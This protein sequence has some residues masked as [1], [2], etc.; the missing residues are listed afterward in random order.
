[1][2]NQNIKL[3]EIKKTISEEDFL[4]TIVVGLGMNE[5]TPGDVFDGEF[6]N[7]TC[8]N[9]HFVSIGGGAKVHCSASI[10]YDY[11]VEKEE[12]DHINKKYKTV[13]E[14]E[15]KWSPYQT[16]Y[17]TENA[18]GF[19][20]NR[21]KTDANGAKAFR[22]LMTT[23]RRDELISVDE[24]LP[25]EILAEKGFT[26]VKDEA[27]K[28]AFEDMKS[29]AI[30]Q[31]K[32]TLP[33][34]R[35]KDFLATAEVDLQYSENYVVPCH[36]VTYTYSGE[37][38]HM[39]A[40]ANGSCIVRGRIPKQSDDIKSNKLGKIVQGISI[41]LSLL[42][43][44]CAV[45]FIREP[46][47]PSVI[48]VLATVAIVSHNWI[49]I[50]YRKDFNHQK[51]KAKKNAVIKILKEKGLRPLSEQEEQEFKSVYKK[52]HKRIKSYGNVFTLAFYIISLGLFLLNNNPDTLV[53]ILLTIMFVGIPAL[54]FYGLVIAPRKK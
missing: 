43:L 11:R 26:E 46:I 42:L 14:T 44:I 41:A 54:I 50:R 12:Y 38:Y 36:H 13:Y 51:V 21:E 15:T 32:N 22:K 33:G 6:G 7:T 5:E 47:F 4:R 16:T 2:E 28:S 39:E 24:T 10:G 25:D 27:L 18:V 8:E 53:Y 23:I 17:S 40:Y 49:D 9:H 52:G 19:S 48:A 1:M 29:D 20:E 3:Y 35:Y 34:D 37:P 30:Q 45:S 31:S